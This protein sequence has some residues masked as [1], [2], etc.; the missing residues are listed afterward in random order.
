MNVKFSDVLPPLHPPSNP[1]L[2]VSWPR[3]RLIG[4]RFANKIK[5]MMCKISR[6]RVRATVAGLGFFDAS[7]LASIDVGKLFAAGL[8][9]T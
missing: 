6:Q 4:D 9:Y 7:N 3:Q 8:C 1:F 2:M 5:H